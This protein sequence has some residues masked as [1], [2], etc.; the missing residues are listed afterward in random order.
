MGHNVDNQDEIVAMNL[1]ASI[2]DIILL[3]GFDWTEKE[4]KTDKFEEVKAR[5]YRG[6]VTQ[7]IKSTP[8]VQWILVDHPGEL[9]PELAELPNIGKDSLDNVLKILN[10]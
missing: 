10:N 9:R 7:A 1:A 3:L 4:K 5:N 8:H 2:C 6:L